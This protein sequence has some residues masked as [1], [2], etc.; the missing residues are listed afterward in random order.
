[1]ASTETPTATDALAALNVRRPTLR[2]RGYRGG[3]LT[4]SVCGVPDFGAAVFTV[5]GRRHVR[6]SGRLRIRL[7]RA[8]RRISVV[9]DVPGV[10][11]TAALRV[12]VTDPAERLKREH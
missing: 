5:D 6:A 12:S 8:P 7:R 10:G 4:V 2:S 3:I 11:R 9:V 1:V